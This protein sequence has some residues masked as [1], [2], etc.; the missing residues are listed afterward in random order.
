MGSTS[1]GVNHFSDKETYV[2]LV[3]CHMRSYIYTGGSKY[4][5]LPNKTA[6]NLWL[7]HT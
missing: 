1:D 6:I 2:K 3:L 5:Y 4:Q 7:K